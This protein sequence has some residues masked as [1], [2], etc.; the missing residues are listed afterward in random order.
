[1]AAS[2]W[3]KVWSP[4]LVMRYGYCDYSCN[5]CGQV[6]PTGAIAPLSLE[7][8]REEVIGKAIIDR[9]RCIPFVED[10][11]CIVCEEMCPLPEKAI[12]LKK[13]AQHQAARPHVI[14]DRCTGCGI[15]ERECPVNGES[16]IRVLPP[17]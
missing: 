9:E 15:C 16:A 6:C 17:G 5:A 11:D 10:R 4:H 7:K 13:G 8:K 14:T 1:M 3:D 12:M 2:G